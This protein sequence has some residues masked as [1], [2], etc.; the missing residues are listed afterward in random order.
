MAAI[1]NMKE[2][3]PELAE[4]KAYILSLTEKLK[5]ANTKIEQLEQTV[6]D[7][8]FCTENIEVTDVCF[9]IAFP[10]RQVCNAV[11]THFNPGGNLVYTQNESRPDV[12]STPIRKIGRPRKLTPTKSIFFFSF[13]G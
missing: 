13:A 8:E 12:N 1:D 5:T 6:R 3:E 2:T 10:N 9:Y 7:M 11:L 4:L